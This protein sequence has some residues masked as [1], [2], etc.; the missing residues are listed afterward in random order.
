MATASGPLNTIVRDGEI[1]PIALTTVKVYRGAAAGIV[2]GTGYGTPLV[3]ANTNHR[4]IGVWTETYDNSAGSA[5]GYFTQV[6]RTGCAKFSQTG[7]T[8]T[9][10]HINTNVYFSD[11][12]TVTLTAGTVWAGTVAAVDAAGG[13]WVDISEATKRTSATS[14]TP[15]SLAG[16]EQD[17]DD[18]S[19]T[20]R[21]AL[22]A[23]LVTADNRVF[24]YAYATTGGVAPEFGAVNNVAALVS[25]A[26]PAQASGAGSIGDVKVTVTV[27]SGAGVTSNG[28]V[29]A[30]ELIGGYVWIGNGTSQHP[31]CRYITG[32][33]VVA[34][35]GG[36]CTLTLDHALIGAVTQS[37]TYIE[38]FYNPYAHMTNGNVTNSGYASVLGVPTA[39]AT[40][41]QYFWL[42]TWGPVWITS[43]GNTGKAANGRDLYFLT[44]GSI[45]GASSTTYAGNQRAGYAMDM[46]TGAASNS[47]LCMLQ[48]DR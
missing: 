41:A 42:Q 26:A 25:A 24:R 21:Y 12:N 47:P 19:S 39:T 28:A 48:L 15:T 30:D 43:D 10:A 11:D 9:F 31:Q 5:G 20:Q 46:S 16:I 35:G 45:V 22:G 40:A 44:N 2:N 27:G 6:H 32:N 8:I 13:V 18:V 14:I 33:T 1:L 3:P 37:V 4:F 29:A 34:A 7:T 38:A 36:V 23:K 17:V